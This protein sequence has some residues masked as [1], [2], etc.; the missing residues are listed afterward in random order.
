[1]KILVSVSARPTIRQLAYK[2]IERETLS[3][4]RQVAKLADSAMDDFLA[5]RMSEAD[6][7][8]WASKE[9]EFKQIGGYSSKSSVIPFDP[10]KRKPKVTTDKPR[11]AG[12]KISDEYMQAV[13]TWEP[14]VDKTRWIN[15]A[16]QALREIT[17]ALNGPNAV[18]RE[19]EVIMRLIEIHKY[20]Y[21]I[22]KAKSEE[23]F[24][25]LHDELAP[26]QKQIQAMFKK[27]KE[28]K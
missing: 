3:E 26:K 5:R 13:Y 11:T 18:E 9:K 23:E 15:L 17:Q 21:K 6:I 12:Q 14:D 19:K 1:M 16:Q 28:S 24:N 27:L 7:K 20:H 8:V 25:R 4:D 22:L 10:S 2:A